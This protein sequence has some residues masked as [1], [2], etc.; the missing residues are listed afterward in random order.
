MNMKKKAQELI[1]AMPD[2]ISSQDLQKELKQLLEIL[3]REEC[4]PELTD[5]APL[6]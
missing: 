3:K 4:S 6:K 2:D 1:E 5:P